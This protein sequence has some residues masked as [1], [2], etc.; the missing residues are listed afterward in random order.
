MIF[1]DKENKIINEELWTDDELENYYV[2]I[3]EDEMEELFLGIE[4]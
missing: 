1:L 4:E 3:R 2:N